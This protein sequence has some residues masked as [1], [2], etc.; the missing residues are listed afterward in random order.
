MQDAEIPGSTVG[1]LNLAMQ[2]AEIPATSVAE[3]FQHP[4]P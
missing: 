2:D 4:Q 3:Q 1:I